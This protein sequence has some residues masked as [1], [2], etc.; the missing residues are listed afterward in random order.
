MIFFYLGREFV[1]GHEP[2]SAVISKH[3]Y[4]VAVAHHRFMAHLAFL[5]CV[6][7]SHKLANHYL[8]GQDVC[9]LV[10]SCR[11]ILFPPLHHVHDFDRSIEIQDLIE[12]LR[13]DP[14]L[15]LFA[16]QSLTELNWA[17]ER[18]LGRFRYEFW[19][20]LI[21]GVPSCRRHG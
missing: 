10:G 9:L 12:G 4:L 6:F 19:T 11:C 3:L 2:S 15:S 20:G 21:Q 5:I 16:V 13:F 18:C 1:N 14:L 7:Y 8:P 17:A